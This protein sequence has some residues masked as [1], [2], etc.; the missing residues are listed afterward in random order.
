MKKSKLTNF[1]IY[2]Y[3]YYYRDLEVNGVDRFIAILGEFWNLF[4]EF[5][6]EFL[7]LGEG[8]YFDEFVIAKALSNGSFDKIFK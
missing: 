3:Y 7:G 8:E 6:L 4:G 2:Y 5:V 1:I